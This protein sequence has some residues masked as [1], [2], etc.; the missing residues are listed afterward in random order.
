MRPETLKLLEEKK[1]FKTQ[2]KTRDVTDAAPLE[3]TTVSSINIE[4]KKSNH[5][6]T[7][8]IPSE[9]TL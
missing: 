7:L 6:K 5:Q 3:I 2:E 9:E 8:K 4:N 1:N